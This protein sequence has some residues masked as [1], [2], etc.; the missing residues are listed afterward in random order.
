MLKQLIQS[1]T[2]LQ[3]GAP[4]Q[5]MKPLAINQTQVRGRKHLLIKKAHVRAKFDDKVE[6]ILPKEIPGLKFPE[7]F[8]RLRK[9]VKK[10]MD[11]T[12]ED[13]KKDAAQKALDNFVQ[14]K[15]GLRMAAFKAQTRHRKYMRRKDRYTKVPKQSLSRWNS[16]EDMKENKIIRDAERAAREARGE[17]FSF[18]K[19]LRAYRESK[20]TPYKI[21]DDE[22]FDQ[23]LQHE[24][25]TYLWRGPPKTRIP[26]TASYSVR[27]YYEQWLPAVY[28]L[29]RRSRIAELIETRERA[30]DE[31]KVNEEMEQ[32]RAAK[33]AE[34]AKLKAERIA[35]RTAVESEW[36]AE[37]NKLKALKREYRLARE[38]VY[39]QAR[40]EF[41]EAMQDDFD[42]WKETPNECKYLRFEFVEGVQWPPRKTP[43]H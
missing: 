36:H 11:L 7:D 38:D 22:S 37:N 42:K 12:T 39:A 20:K 25:Q 31:R 2:K 40:S 9:V 30:I 15:W 18:K 32:K 23:M 13:Q 3:W 21:L 28:E 19:F 41:L 14:G 6:L 5:I 34:K 4:T 29:R 33:L 27:Q 16:I 1:T 8:D 26:A 43:Y 24:I 35:Y 10:A 17:P